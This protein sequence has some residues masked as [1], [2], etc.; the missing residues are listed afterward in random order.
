MATT[1]TRKKKTEGQPDSIV[2]M[3]TSIGEDLVLRSNPDDEAV[4]TFVEEHTK[5]YVAGQPGGPSG[6]QPYRIFNALR[7]PNEADY[8]LGEADGVEID[9]SDLL[10]S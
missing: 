8:L 6:I 10:P 5:R 1:R 9:I 7:Y 4:R 3:N 2:V